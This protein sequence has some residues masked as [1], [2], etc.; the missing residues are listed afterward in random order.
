MVAEGRLP[1]FIVLVVYLLVLVALG[2]WKARR[3][4]TQEDFSL[5]GRGLPTF[6]LIGTLL[7]TWIGTGSIFGNA[8]EAYRV[9][10]DALLIPIAG[11]SGVLLL[12]FLAP[13]IRRFGQFTIQDILE[14]RFGPVARVLGTVALLLAYVII[15][16]YQFRAGAT[17]LTYLLPG[18]SSGLAVCA[19]ALFVVLYTALAGMISV[20]YTDVANGIL[21]LLGIFLALPIVANATGGVGAAIE[22]LEPAQRT[23][24]G[25]YDMGR[26]V[27]VLLPAFLLILGDANMVQRFFSARSPESARRSAAGMFV[28]VIVLEWGIILL[29]LLGAGLVAQGK[30]SAPANE[31]HVIIHLAFEALP[32]WLGATLV[33]TVVAVVVSTA[34]SYLLSPATSIVRDVV[35]RFF[36]PQM[37]DREAVLL[38]RIVVVVLG[39]LALGLAFLS[40]EF[41]SVALFA[42]TIYGAGVTPALLAAYFWKRATSAGAVAS[43]IAGVVSAILWEV[44]ARGQNPIAEFAETWS[45]DAVVPAITTSLVVLVLV[46]LATPPPDAARASA[47]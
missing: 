42:Y 30:L 22:A 32:V 24:F 16:S 44:L 17:V 34:D 3:V 37:A 4:K 7:A 9:G 12:Y 20:A 2:A 11:A 31:A 8:E 19:V 40:S 26:L 21:I 1:H 23:F 35:Q 33:A 47:V 39:L 41:F 43:M 5:A 14:A 28:G 45:V 15:V 13:R 36:R 29:A 46:S 18:L 38:G 25:T 27:S 10:L 6:V